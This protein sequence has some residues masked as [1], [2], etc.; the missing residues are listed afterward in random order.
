MKWLDHTS[1][2]DGAR[3]CVLLGY[4]LSYVLIVAGVFLF[5]LSVAQL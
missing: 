2:I 4:L 1:W 5:V 3:V